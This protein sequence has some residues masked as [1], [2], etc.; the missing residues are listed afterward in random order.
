MSTAAPQLRAAVISTS[1]LTEIADGVWVIPD[2]DHTL[3]VPNIGIVVGAGATLII[4][5]GFGADNARA[6]LDQARRLNRPTGVSSSPLSSKA[7][8]GS[9]RGFFRR[10]RH[11]RAGLG[12]SGPEH[13]GRYVWGDRGDATVR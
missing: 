12:L 6:V 8:T 1:G 13:R 10:L 9:G 7:V 11:G 5:T 2:A 3:L 4:D